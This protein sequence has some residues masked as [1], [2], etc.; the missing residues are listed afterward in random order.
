MAQTTTDTSFRPVF[1]TAALPIVYY[2]IYILKTLVSIQKK[3]EEEN[4]KTHLW[5]K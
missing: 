4:K 2:N 5:P 1:V 3:K